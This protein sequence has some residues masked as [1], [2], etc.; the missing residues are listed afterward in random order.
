MKRSLRM[1]AI[2]LEYPPCSIGGY[3]VMCAQVCEW[4]RQRG[5]GIQ[6]LTTVPLA[7]LS[8]G[9]GPLWEGPIP[10]RRTLHSYWD[11]RNCLY[12][13][14]GEA[15][16]IERENQAQ[17]RDILAEYRPDVVSFWHMGT[18]SLGLIT[19]T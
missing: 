14:F 5:H 19:T 8:L 13:P 18:M 10:V 15:L 3:G 12:P 16:A 6:V 17:L 7:T 9:K 4:L 2:S 11:G 1:L